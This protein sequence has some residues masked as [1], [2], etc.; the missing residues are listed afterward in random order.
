ML[1]ERVFSI[2]MNSMPDKQTGD[3][4]APVLGSE[5]GIQ[6]AFGRYRTALDKYRRCQLAPNTVGPCPTNDKPPKDV[7]QHL[8]QF[9]HTSRTH[10]GHTGVL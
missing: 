7:Q 1:A 9:A 2:L 4:H 5:G 6:E 3:E 10:H 8:G